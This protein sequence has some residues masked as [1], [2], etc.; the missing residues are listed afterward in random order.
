MDFDGHSI[1]SGSSDQTIKVWNRATGDCLHTMAG[2]TELVR[3]LQMDRPSDRI[4]SGS[5]DGS[6]KIWN[7]DKGTLIRSLNDK[8]EGR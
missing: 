1:V 8:V 7:M 3:T 6:I 5:Y 2:H 4:V